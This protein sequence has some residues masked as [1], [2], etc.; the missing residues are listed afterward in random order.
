MIGRQAICV[1]DARHWKSQQH[2]VAVLGGAE[3]EVVNGK[4]ALDVGVDGV[5]GAGDERCLVDG[6]PGWVHA[7]QL[8][9]L[10]AVESQR[11]ACKDGDGCAAGGVG[12]RYGPGADGGRGDGHK[13]GGGRS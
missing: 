5:L 6:E 10:E 2:D 3:L 9:E 8:D 13:T 12:A 11:A 1:I 4:S 7:T